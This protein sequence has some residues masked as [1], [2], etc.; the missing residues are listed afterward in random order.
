MRLLF[1]APSPP[2]PTAGGGS[3]RMF[4]V[5][6]F[7]G[8]RFDLDLVAPAYAGADE[9]V[10]LLRGSCRDIVFVTPAP[11]GLR[12][13]V[14]RLG[15][16]EKD[17]A[18]AATIRRRLAE[19][20]YAA[21]QVEKPAMLPY[22][23]KGTGVPVVLD[24]FAFGQAGAWRALRHEPGALTRARNALRLIRFTTFDTFCWPALR[25]ILVVSE[26]DRAR[27]RRARPEAAVVVVPNGVDCGAIRPKP[28]GNGGPPVLVFSGDMSFE[29]NVDAAVLL[30]TRIFPDVLRVHPDALL[31]LVGRN[32]DRRVRALGGET[33]TVT[34][35]VAD[36]LPHLH[37]ATV[38]VAPHFTG[39]GT[40]TKLLE[41]MAAGLPIVTTS[42]GIEGIEAGDGREVVIA[43][44]PAA[45]AAAILRLLSLPDERRRLGA[46]ARHLAEE[47][48][49]WPRC[50]APLEKLY[51]GLLPARAT[52]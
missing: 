22:L 39:A 10:R 40:R 32:P 9:A 36:M 19:N 42:V 8:E 17:P 28:T 27:C 4:H 29:P 24:T 3:L 34:G 45:T 26:V 41:A 6:R 48:Y 37:G 15:P 20:T 35:E 18:L 11:G 12:R 38:Y 2:L 33:V 47:R 5:V 52:G 16:Y 50:L 13:R 1:L 43:D 25:C 30:A 14:L 44:D 31:R 49:D 23:P 51:A 46:A 21:I 7:L